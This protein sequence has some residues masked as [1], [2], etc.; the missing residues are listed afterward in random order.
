MLIKLIKHDLIATKHE[1]FG[2]YLGY[3]LLSVVAPFL[4]RN[5]PEWLQ[6][7][8]VFAVV[9]VLIAIIVIT[10]L[11][12][13]RLFQKRLYSHEGYLTWTL[14]VSVKLN[15]LSKI[16]VGVIWNIASFVVVWVGAMIA[17]LIYLS[18]IGVYNEVLNIL[19]MVL[20]E[21]GFLMKMVQ[22][23][24]VFLPQ[25]IV[26]LF[27]SVIFLLFVITFVN[28]SW[29]KK[30]RQA[31]GVV[32]YFGLSLLIDALSTTL[33]TKPAIVTNLDPN[34]M[35]INP[36]DPI[37]SA[38]PLLRNFAYTIDIPVLLA[39][40]ALQGAIVVIMSIAILYFVEKKMEI[41]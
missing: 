9:G 38:I 18:Q 35:A 19:N 12:I 4:V 37:N 36:F 25:S 29:V 30:G 2:I 20:V 33:I 39:T 34:G 14:P 31:I 10:L 17:S 3:L 1:F 40:I 27:Y 11:A 41:E 21:T 5:G 24:L 8:S 6:V 22:L 16:I 32:M 23:G 28:T 7:L 15:L 13:I 26:S